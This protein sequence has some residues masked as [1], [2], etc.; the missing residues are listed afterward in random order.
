MSRSGSRLWAMHCAMVSAVPDN[1]LGAER[2][3]AVR[4]A[5]V[6]CTAVTH[7]APGAWGCIS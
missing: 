3:A 6:D 2:V 4:G 5:G 7:A 1:A